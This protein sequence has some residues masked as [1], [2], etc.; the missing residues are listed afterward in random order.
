VDER[1]RKT[2]RKSAQQ[3]HREHLQRIFFVQSLVT[4]RELTCVQAVAV[5][6]DVAER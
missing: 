4:V 1:K 3:S 2:E 5:G 6:C